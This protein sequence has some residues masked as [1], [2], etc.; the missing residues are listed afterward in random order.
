MYPKIGGQ[1]PSYLYQSLKQYKTGERQNAVMAGM[2]SNLSDEDMRDLAA[3]YGSVE[4]DL[5]TLP[6]DDLD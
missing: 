5:Y 1:H 3:Y 6:L 4:G 2:V